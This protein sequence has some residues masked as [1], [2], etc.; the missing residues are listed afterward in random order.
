MSFVYDGQLLK[1]NYL[2]TKTMQTLVREN[3]TISVKT[4]DNLWQD[5]AEFEVYCPSHSLHSQKCE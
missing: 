2:T 5:K 4:S 1:N 3:A